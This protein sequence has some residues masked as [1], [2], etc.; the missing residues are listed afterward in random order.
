MTWGIT[1]PGIQ[2]REA[3]G[4]TSGRF[5]V[6]QWIARVF[7]SFKTF[8]QHVINEGLEPASDFPSGPYPSDK[9]TC[10]SD[11]MVEYQTPSHSKGLGTMSRL[12]AGDYPIS[13]VAILQGQN[14]PSLLFLALRLPSGLNDLASPIIRGLE[15]QGKASATQ[16]EVSQEQ[17]VAPNDREQYRSSNDLRA[18]DINGFALDMTVQEVQAVAHHPLRS[19]GAGQYK[20]AVDNV[21]YDFGFSVLGHLYRI[22]LS[23][24]LGN[25]VP[26]EHFARTLT[27]KLSRKF[28]PPQRNQ[29]PGGPAA[30]EYFEQY[31]E[32]G[33]PVINRTTVSLDAWIVGG[34]GQP[35]LLNIKLMDFR[36]MRRDLAAANSGPRSHA[37]A[38]TK[39]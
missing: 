19:I 34:W 38:S 14:P 26:D 30:W 8:V 15:E 21:D 35:I 13:G 10:K 3:N 17:E 20:V 24:N 29:L 16:K 12:Q 36:I 32:T 11:R 37:E 5:E 28:G 31:R 18:H 1:G 4:E 39:F 2:L 9:L 22:D 33:G 6:A 7:P 23:Q 27:E 25:F